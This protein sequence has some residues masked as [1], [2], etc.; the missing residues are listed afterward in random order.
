MIFKNLINKI[1]KKFTVEV[2][3]IPPW[4]RE[5]FYDYTWGESLNEILF[6][7]GE[8]SDDFI[9]YTSDANLEEDIA[10]KINFVA[11]TDNFIYYAHYDNTDDEEE[12]SGFKLIPISQHGHDFLE[13]NISKTIH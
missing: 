7:T 12:V 3:V 1:K 6:F 8:N 2:E 10:H 4:L 5:Q 13:G 11:Y 9:A